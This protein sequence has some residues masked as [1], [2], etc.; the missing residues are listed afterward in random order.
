MVFTTINKVARMDDYLPTK[1]I[2]ELEP[3]KYY[4]LRRFERR[5]QNSGRS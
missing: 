3:M 1:K 4:K 5:L 2:I